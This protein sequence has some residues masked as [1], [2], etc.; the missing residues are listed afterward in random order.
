MT[1]ETKASIKFPEPQH[2]LAE[3]SAV[4]SL[5]GNHGSTLLHATPTPPSS[6]V[7]GTSTLHTSGH[8]KPNHSE[9][10]FLQRVD[11]TEE[12]VRQGLN[13]ALVTS[14]PAPLLTVVIPVY[15]EVHTVARVVDS[16]LALPVEKQVVIVDDGSSDGT[17]QVLQRY[18][19][20][21]GIEVLIH[22]RNQGK[23]AAL[24]NGFRLANGDIIIVQDADLEYDPR[25]ILKVIQ[26]IVDGKSNVVYGSR[27]MQGHI[28]DPSWMHRIGNW[29][30]TTLSNQ[31][32]R[33]SLTD[34]ETCY[35][36]IRREILQS[37]NIE[38]KRFGFEPEITAKLAKRGISIVEVPISYK[39]RGWDEGKKIGVKDLFSTLWCIIRYRFGA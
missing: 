6:T 32:T 17:Q 16:V 29:I 14:F 2:D 36:A 10:T 22:D 23:G 13:E 19:N 33:S 35:K 37:I 1:T 38:Q 11:S 25:D 5:V 31:M 8:G 34:M 20:R 24:Q 3:A 4:S 15:N 30:L 12:L 9:C 28:Q 26:P 7:D 27:Y 39:S 21:A 18:R